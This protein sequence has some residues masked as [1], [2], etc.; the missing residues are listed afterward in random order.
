MGSQRTNW[1]TTCPERK[2]SFRYLRDFGRAI[3]QTRYPGCR[4]CSERKIF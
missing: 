4:V 3:R 1:Q 2:G